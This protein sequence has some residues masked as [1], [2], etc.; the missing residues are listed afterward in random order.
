MTISASLAKAL[1]NAASVRKW[2]PATGHVYQLPSSQSQPSNRGRES[3]DATPA[4]DA[5]AATR[6]APASQKTNGT[7]QDE[8]SLERAAEEAFMIHM[9]YGGDY[10]D[11]NP[12]TGRPGEFH[13]SSTGRKPA[14]PPSLDPKK[15]P[16]GGMNGPTPINTKLDTKKD[17]KTEKTPKSATMP[18]PK[19]KKSRISA[20]NTPAAT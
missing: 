15:G 9:R 16:G 20:A 19:R 10:I 18:K 14:L 7:R 4:P 13:L 11:K 2:H 12:I 1:P 6:P 5:A 17:G 8:N 3:K